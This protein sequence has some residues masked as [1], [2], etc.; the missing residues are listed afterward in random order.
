MAGMCTL[1]GII[2]IAITEHS[3]QVR[4]GWAR[5]GLLM[6]W[7]LPCATGCENTN[8]GTDVKLYGVVVHDTRRGFKE[9][10]GKVWWYG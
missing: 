1:V 5:C 7:Y 2:R 4:I 10:I 9:Y 8:E 3:I 6:F